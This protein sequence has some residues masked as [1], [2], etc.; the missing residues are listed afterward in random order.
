MAEIGDSIVVPEALEFLVELAGTV[1]PGLFAEVGVYKGGSA[2]RLAQFGREL[3]LFDTFTGTPVAGAGDDHAIGDFGDTDAAQVIA[4]LPAAIF[5]IGIFPDTLPADLSGFAFVH[6]DCDQYASVR[7]CIAYLGPR[8]VPGGIIL[9]D[10][11]A[12]LD[13]ATRAVDEAFPPAAIKRSPQGKAYVV[14]NNEEI[15]TQ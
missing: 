12:C 2:L 3:H 11:Y 4:M 15:S 14:F 6:A 9:F 1:P 7:D 8:M 5:H 10:D 13:S